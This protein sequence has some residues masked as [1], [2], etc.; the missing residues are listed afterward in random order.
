VLYI[1]ATEIVMCNGQNRPRSPHVPPQIFIPLPDVH[2][3]YNLKEPEEVSNSLLLK[4]SSEIF[5]PP[6]SK[7]LYDS[8][9]FQRFG[10]DIT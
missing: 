8:L 9:S 4:L 2:V 7:C 6:L 3:S 10:F 1:L 5:E